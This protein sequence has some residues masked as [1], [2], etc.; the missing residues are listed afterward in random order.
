MLSAPEHHLNE[1]AGNEKGNKEHPYDVK[2]PKPQLFTGDP[3]G[4]EYRNGRYAKGNEQPKYS[5]K[6]IGIKVVMDHVSGFVNNRTTT[7]KPVYN[8][9]MIYQII[10]DKQ[11]CKQQKGCKE[12]DSFC[13]YLL[14]IFRNLFS[15]LYTLAVKLQ[16][17][18]PE[19]DRYM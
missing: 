12:N 9:M 14:H 10:R 13:H 8:E 11:N 17:K 7:A 1:L 4:Q 2:D 16:G 3:L 6:I 18:A 15:Q 5:G 19:S